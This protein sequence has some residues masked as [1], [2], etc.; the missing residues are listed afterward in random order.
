M[1]RT[2]AV[3]QP[4][5]DPRQLSLVKDPD[6]RP[7]LKWVG[8]KTQL[9]DQLQPLLPATFRNYFEP[10]VGG[11][12][13]FFDLRA[14]WRLENEVTLSDVNS[15][16]IECYAA[17]RDDVEGVIRVLRDHV[18]E[19]DHYYRVRGLDRAGLSA[20]E[21][22]ARTI[23]LNKTGFNGLYRVNRS[24]RFNVPFGRFTNPLF[25]D[26]E[27]LRA[28]SRALRS[29][30]LVNGDFSSV[31]ET[32]KKGDFVYFD[33]PYVP[34]SPTSDFTGYIP[35]GFGEAE[36]KKLAKVFAKLARR[37]VHVMLSNSETPLVRELYADFDVEVVY[38]SRSVNSNITRR[39][40]LPELVVRSYGGKKAGAKKA[41]KAAAK[42]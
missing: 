2:A 22:A 10:F 30:K 15:E 34:L 36:Q 13:L 5:P 6:P 16:L 35:G 9:L 27:N 19:S 17:V 1:G 37:G 33:P 21:S 41:A 23:Y 12:A 32:A 42:Q 24:G 11:A 8:G 3:Q 38:A 40:K 14:R 25:C 29:V 4:R 28:V 7:F 26:V 18:Y 39:G 31:I 20:A